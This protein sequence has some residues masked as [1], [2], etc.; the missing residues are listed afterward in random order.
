MPVT[1]SAVKAL[2]VSIRRRAE[3]L[4]VKRSLKSALKGISKEKIAA[5]FSAIDKAVKF[6][7]IHQNK[8]NRLKSQLAKKYG[9]PV[10]RSKKLQGKS[11]KKKTRR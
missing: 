7:V 9:S 2:R 1:R 11:P 6:G 3:N 5:T 10:R 4:G 8:A